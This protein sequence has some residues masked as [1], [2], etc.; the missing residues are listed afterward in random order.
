[1]NATNLRKINYKANLNKQNLINS[2]LSS[3]SSESKIIPERIKNC[4][5]IYKS[6]RYQK[7][8]SK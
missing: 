4:T 5:N 8:N 7:K 2:S 3:L 6:F 1:M